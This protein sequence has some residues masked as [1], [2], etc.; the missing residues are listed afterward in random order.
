MGTLFERIGG[1]GAMMAAVNLF[2]EKV[3]ADELVG[4][5]FTELDM[6]KQTMKQVAF[7]SRALG[8]PKE[9]H[10][11]DLRE[12]HAHL[13]LTDAHFDRVAELLTSTL[14]E[15][16]VP[17]DLIGEVGGIVESTRDAVLIR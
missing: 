5:F 6:D 8:G 9:F 12:A 14:K 2:Y 15:M 13:G 10:G 17:D 4:P 3:C 1:D 7:L 11:R 16:D